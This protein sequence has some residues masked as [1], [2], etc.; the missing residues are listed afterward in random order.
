MENQF[1]L[2]RD[3]AVQLYPKGFDLSIAEACELFK[4]NP[5]IDVE[6]I[7]FGFPITDDFTVINNGEARFI[8]MGE[9]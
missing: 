1:K 4:L 2:L 5:E 9:V 7:F 8:Y 6:T 3:L